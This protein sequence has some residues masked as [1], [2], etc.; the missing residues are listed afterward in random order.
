MFGNFDYEKL[1]K[2]ADN[3]RA[4]YSSAPAFPHIFIDD[5]ANE[6]KLSIVEKDFS[7]L[8]KLEWW[9]Y[10]NPLEKKLAFDKVHLLPQSLKE[11]LVEMN[12]LPFIDFLESLTGIKGLIP[13]P[14]F[15]GGGLHKIP[16]GG[17]LG[18][19]VVLSF[20]ILDAL[21]IPA[22]CHFIAVEK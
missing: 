9:S 19:N 14:S 5:F 16:R 6:S 11:I 15:A 17:K 8:P 21:G 3:H 10:D 7:S 12:S 13:D 20:E 1:S 18:L 22:D 4:A 2:F